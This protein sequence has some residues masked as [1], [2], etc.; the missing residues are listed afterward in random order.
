MTTTDQPGSDTTP[1]PLRCGCCGRSKPADRLS[2]LGLTPGVHICAGCALWAARRA[3]GLPD[4]HRLTHAIA[5]LARWRRGHDH[6]DGGT[7]NSAIA[8]LPSTDLDRTIAFWRPLGF[9]VIGRYDGYLVTHADGVE[10]HFSRD[11]DAAAGAPAR[12]FLHVQDAADLFTRLQSE[13]VAGLEPLQDQDYGLREF[14]ITDP[15]GNR[16]RIGSSLD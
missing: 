10:I 16:I 4:L 3:S 13:H 9:D 6:H 7:V 14:V 1:S 12:V 5:H 15:D 8:I 2:G 11:Q